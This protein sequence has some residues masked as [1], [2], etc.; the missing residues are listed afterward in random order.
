MPFSPDRPP[1]LTGERVL[2]PEEKDFLRRELIAG[3]LRVVEA[4]E[5]VYLPANEVPPMGCLPLTKARYAKFEAWIHRLSEGRYSPPECDQFFLTDNIKN[6]VRWY[7][8]LQSLTVG[9]PLPPDILEQFGPP[10]PDPD[11]FIFEPGDVP[12]WSELPSKT[13]IEEEF[14]LDYI[15]PEY[16]AGRKLK[17]PRDALHITSEGLKHRLGFDPVQQDLLDEG[18]AVEQPE[19]REAFLR[20]VDIDFLPETLPPAKIFEIGDLI[21]QK[22]AKEPGHADYLTTKELLDAFDEAGVRPA[23]LKELL[24]YSKK[25][26]KA[27]QSLSGPISEKEKTQRADAQSI[28]AL[29]SIWSLVAPGSRMINKRA[30]PTLSLNAGRRELYPYYFSLDWFK[31]SR[32]LVFRK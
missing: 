30:V 29:G 2:S 6:V 18:Y 10:R 19:K 15:S 11:E 23:T 1:P 14:G 31:T 24:A 4:Y 5:D 32:F 25:F 16:P 7:E 12:T 8:A 13:E 20:S 3:I 28:H 9:T 27:K 17:D 22:I 21:E 26:W